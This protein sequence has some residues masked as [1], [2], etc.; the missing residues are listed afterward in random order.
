MGTSLKRNTRYMN[1]SYISQAVILICTVYVPC[2]NYHIRSPTTH[3]LVAC[4]SSVRGH[5]HSS[6][7]HPHSHC[8]QYGHRCQ[9][10]S[11]W[12]CSDWGRLIGP[13]YHVI[14]VVLPPGYWLYYPFGFLYNRYC[15]IIITARYCTIIITTLLHKHCIVKASKYRSYTHNK[16]AV[17][18][19]MHTPDALRD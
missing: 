6:P 12:L 8:P 16:C 1:F 19:I 2:V 11:R 4:S 13:L 7:H 5:W 18:T 17:E 10:F 14:V 9:G 15:T 3:H